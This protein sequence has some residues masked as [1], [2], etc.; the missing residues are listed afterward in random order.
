MLLV[1]CLFTVAEFYMTTET[2]PFSQDEIVKMFSDTLNKVSI[3]NTQ[4]A[5]LVAFWSCVEHYAYD[6]VKR[7][8]SQSGNFTYTRFAQLCSACGVN[9]DETSKVEKHSGQSNILLQSRSYV[10]NVVQHVVACC[11]PLAREKSTF[12]SLRWIHFPRTH[13][14]LAI[15]GQAY[16]E[17]QLQSGAGRYLSL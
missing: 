6:I 7:D 15:S 13:S 11:L 1:K 3:T 5:A 8:L 4:E 2:L 12:L 14:L 17:F 10:V 9:L 16:I